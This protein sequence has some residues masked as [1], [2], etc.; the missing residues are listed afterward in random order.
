M[1]Q[2]KQKQCGI[3]GIV[4]FNVK[5]PPLQ[6]TSFISINTCHSVVPVGVNIGVSTQMSCF[7]HE[8]SE[9]EPIM[10]R[11]KFRQLQSET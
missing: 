7:H 11:D 2:S 8:Q 9:S 5:Q 4:V 1:S 3:M 6:L 10:S